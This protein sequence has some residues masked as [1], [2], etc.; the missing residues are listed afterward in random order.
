[1][2]RPKAAPSRLDHLLLSGGWNVHMH[3]LPRFKPQRSNW[4][5]RAVIRRHRCR[6]QNH[7]HRKTPYAPP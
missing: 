6:S 3:I 4:R 1:M 7:R 5:L 2:I